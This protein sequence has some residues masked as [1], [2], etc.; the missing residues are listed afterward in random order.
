MLGTR[1][2]RRLSAIQRSAARNASGALVIVV[3]MGGCSSTSPTIPTGTS[4]PTGVAQVSGLVVDVTTNAGIAGETLE[5]YQSG[6]FPSGA[7]V[8]FAARIIAESTGTYRVS[9]PRTG[10]YVVSIGAASF[11]A[12]VYV[13]TRSYLTDLAIGHT[14]C[15]IMYGWVFDESTSRPVSGARITWVD[16]DATSTAD[17]MYVLNLGCRSNGYGSGTSAIGITH[18][19]YV[20]QGEFGTRRE[21]L[22][23]GWLKRQDFALI[24][25]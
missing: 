19:G 20:A 1:G 16:T 3:L 10:M 5:W 25:R 21:F 8:E 24:P 14:D 22:A 4:T 17:G 11:A 23:G 7:S 9:L 13:P 15:P 2:N 12:R 18:P 6:Q